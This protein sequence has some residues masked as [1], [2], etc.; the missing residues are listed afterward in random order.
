V[1]YALAY[2][3]IDPLNSNLIDYPWFKFIHGKPSVNEITVAA[4]QYNYL[5]PIKLEDRIYLGGKRLDRIWHY[6]DKK[7]MDTING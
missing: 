2:R 4:D 3:I 1:V 7:L 6:H 5:Y